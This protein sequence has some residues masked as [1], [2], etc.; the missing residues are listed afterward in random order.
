MNRKATL[1]IIIGLVISSCFTKKVKND[2]SQENSIKDKFF[3][4]YDKPELLVDLESSQDDGL[5]LEFDLHFF[6]DY[7]RHYSITP[8][9]VIPFAGTGSNGIHFGF[10]TD[11]GNEKKL[12]NAPI[13]VVCPPC[14]PPVKLVAKNL[15]DFVSV[16]M[17]VGDATYLTN[18]YESD[19]EFINE[20]IEYELFA[21]KDVYKNPDKE[22]VNEILQENTSNRLNTKSRIKKE[23]GIY[24]MKN[25]CDYQ[26]LIK[27]RRA[28]NTQIKDMYGLGIK[29]ECP[30]LE[31]YSNR[32]ISV[33]EIDSF[34]N[35]ANRCEKLQF[36]R[37]STMI[38]ILA[39]NYNIE[40]LDCLVKH[41]NNDGFLRES[42]ILES[43][44]K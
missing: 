39:R 15:R 6:I 12:D 28:K 16:V 9:D 13:V 5:R 38:F 30:K 19:I 33:Q 8:I 20:L 22:L 40:E 44:Y 36:Y 4:N 43:E 32:R 1:L 26:K 17:A 24:P 2:I 10:L 11:F 41:L 7:D 25:V 31:A 21:A 23:F 34:L 3:G 18:H 42:K 27:K 29:S 14:D 37:N 35:K